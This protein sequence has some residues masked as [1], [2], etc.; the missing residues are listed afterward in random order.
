LA[1][2]YGVAADN[3]PVD[4]EWKMFGPERQL[5]IKQI[6]PFEKGK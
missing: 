3:F 2:V 6:R 4:I 1:T 5:I